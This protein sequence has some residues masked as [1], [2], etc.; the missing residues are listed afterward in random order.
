M[1]GLTLDNLI[2]MLND[3][4]AP[5]DLATI[6]V[7]L[8]RTK[9]LQKLRIWPIDLT[10]DAAIKHLVKSKRTLPNQGIKKWKQGHDDDGLWNPKR[11]A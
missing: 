2:V 6:Y 7:G 4:T 5:H 11:L 8:S 3:Q 9:V 1:Q 10:S